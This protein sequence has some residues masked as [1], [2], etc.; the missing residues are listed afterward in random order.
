MPRCT[1]KI[2]TSVI[3][4]M[5]SSEK[6]CAKVI[7][8]VDRNAFENDGSKGKGLDQKKHSDNFQSELSEYARHPNNKKCV[9]FQSSSCKAAHEAKQTAPYNHLMAQY[10]Y[11]STANISYISYMFFDDDMKTYPHIS[12]KISRNH[13]TRGVIRYTHVRRLT[14]GKNPT[15][16]VL[17]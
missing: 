4:G 13:G 17:N 9:F 1:I 12:W 11:E 16:F 8:K 7:G 3:D 6:D 5:K 14:T 15:D 10:M 2:K